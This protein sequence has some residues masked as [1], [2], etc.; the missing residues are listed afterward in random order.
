M[1]T[2]VIWG[3]WWWWW[4]VVVG[5]VVLYPVTEVISPRLV[6]SF[7]DPGALWRVHGR[8]TQP[9]LVFVSIKGKKKKAFLLRDRRT[10]FFLQPHILRQGKARDKSTGPGPV[11]Q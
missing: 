1:I 3:Q 8:G 6:T 11:H 7:P 4:W 5:G 10:S 2:C 9:F